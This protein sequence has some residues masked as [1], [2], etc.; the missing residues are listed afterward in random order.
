MDLEDPTRSPHEDGAG[1]GEDDEDPFQKPKQLP[2]DLPTSLDDR[3]PFQTYG[4]ETEMYDA[5][6]GQSQFLTNPV[7]A[8]PL[9]FNLAL[10]APVYDDDTTPRLEDGESRLMTMLAAQAQ[11][12]EE[13]DTG[14][15]EVTIAEDPKITKDEKRS[16][17]Q[18]ILNM[19]ASNGDVERIQRLF[20]GKAKDFVDVNMPDEEGTPPL[21]YASCFGHNEVVEALLSAGAD[22]DRCD[23][24]QWSPLMWATTNR[25]KGIAKILLD[26]GASPDIK[27]SSGGTALDFVQPGSDFSKYLSDNGYNFGHEGFQ[28]DF[29]DSGFAQ[30]RFEEEMAENELKRRMLMQES[31]ANLE[32]DISTLG[33]DEQP[34]SP[35]ELDEQEEFIWD[36]CVGDQMFVFQENDLDR[37]LDLVITNMTPQRTPSQK[38]VPANLIFLM[39]RYAH[40]HMTEPLLE[41]VLT[42]AMDRINEVVERHQWDM[43]ILAFWIANATLLLHYMKKD[44]GLAEATTKFQLELAELINEIFILVIRDAERRMNKVLETAL[45]D[46]ETIPGFEDVAFQ[47]EWK[48][49]KAKSK[50][51]EPEPLEKRFRPPSPKR[52]AQ[53]SPRNI[54]SLLS[55]TLFVLD[56]Y[57]V[58]SVITAQILAQ[59][60]YWLGAEI[61][62]RIMTNRRYM[63]RTK[64]MQIRMNVSQLEDWARTNNRQPEHYE[65]GATTM[66]GE[67]TIE[68]ARRHLAPVIQ[69]L[70]W[71]QCFSSLGDDEESLRN[72]LSQLRRLSPTQ[73]IHAVKHYRQEVGEKGLT[74]PFMKFLIALDRGQQSLLPSTS[75]ATST[76][77]NLPSSSTPSQAAKQPTE[78]SS[79]TSTPT[80]AVKNG[81]HTTPIPSEA[82]TLPIPPTT[83]SKP[84]TIIPISSPSN[85]PDDPT[86]KTGF[87]TSK[88]ITQDPALMLPFS[89]P[90]STDMLIT[91]GA[92]FGGVNRERE[93]KY[94]PSVPPEWLGKLGVE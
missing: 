21:I 27:S 44:T 46:H 70:Q 41:D 39:A 77:T 69:L 11:H 80:S 89:L 17:L 73:L 75:D 55:S 62:N 12:R 86:S 33:F 87:S 76:P 48:L 4:G 45:L 52:R 84:S 36:R 14:E 94:V 88:S 23:R 42:N 79:S 8:K 90:S 47:G 16:V 78:P 56:L 49:L 31:A 91:Y 18:K 43:T 6:Q 57:D 10:D 92:G 59:L 63:A 13:V 93:R 32:V 20:N 61:F 7:P 35:T 2:P 85:I 9:D 83:P 66:T 1:F 34:E 40:Y 53:T 64:A 65:H 29:Y 71:L 72:T 67:N 81:N 30:D 22:V 50:P 51:K 58:H 26:H 28:D 68:A 82:T 19:A 54:T 3:R 74:K 60:F 24:N 5:W 25:H 37:I 15:D 38:P